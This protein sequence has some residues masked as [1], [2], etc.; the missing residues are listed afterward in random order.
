MHGRKKKKIEHAEPDFT[1]MIDC[2]FLLLMFNMMV[3]TLTGGGIKLN[4]PETENAKGADAHEAIE[5]ILKEPEQKGDDAIIVL[6]AADK[7][8][9]SLDD[10]KDY[11]EQEKLALGSQTLQVVIKA[12]KKVAARDVLNVAKLV[13]AVGGKILVAVQ[14][15]Q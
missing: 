12:E 1:A 13:G 15:P 11:L 5:I 14:H 2:M 8:N 9:A 6:R 10:V 4:I 7:L 3:F